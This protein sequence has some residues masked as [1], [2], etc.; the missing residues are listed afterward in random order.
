[1]QEVD[2]LLLL[3]SLVSW[4]KIKMTAMSPRELTPTHLVLNIQIFDVFGVGL[5]EF[6]A[7]CDVAAH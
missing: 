4:K 3:F 6:F 5:D 1:M 2:C 7:G